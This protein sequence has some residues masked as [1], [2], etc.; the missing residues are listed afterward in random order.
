VTAP[1]VRSRWRS[2]EALGTARSNGRSDHRQAASTVI[3]VRFEEGQLVRRGDLLIELDARGAR[4]SRR[5]RRRWPSKR[6]RTKP[7]PVAQR[8]LSG[9]ARDDQATLLANEARVAASQ[10]RLSDADPRAIRRAHG[11]AARRRRRW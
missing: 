4:P 8:A 10:A 5:P 1:V 3:S 7:R 6:L 9:S 2:G 11:I